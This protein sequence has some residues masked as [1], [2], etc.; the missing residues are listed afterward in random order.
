MVETSLPDMVPSAKPAPDVPDTGPGPF[1][2]E[3]VA[4]QK[5]ASALSW[6]PPCSNLLATCRGGPQSKKCPPVFE[7]RLCQ[8]V[9]CGCRRPAAPGGVHRQGEGAAGSSPTT[10]P[11]YKRDPRELVAPA[12]RPPGRRRARL[13]GPTVSVVRSFAAGVRAEGAA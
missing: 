6:T 11:F 7:T 9:A 2:S 3:Q 12:L 8:G 4:R 13:A 10:G 1:A 5:A